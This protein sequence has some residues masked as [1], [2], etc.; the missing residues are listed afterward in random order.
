M[1]GPASV[2][3]ARVSCEDNGRQKVMCMG[4]KVKQLYLC[5]RNCCE[6][7]V[8]ASACGTLKNAR[9]QSTESTLF[10]YLPPSRP[11]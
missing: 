6:N 1:V 9:V 3:V 10:L 8:D 4:L 11:D 2:G 5:L 7:V